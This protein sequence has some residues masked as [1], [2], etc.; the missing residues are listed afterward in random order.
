MHDIQTPDIASVERTFQGLEL[1][2]EQRDNGIFAAI[3]KALLS[4]SNQWMRAPDIVDRIRGWKLT[5][6]DGQLSGKT[7]TST[8]QGTI[9]TALKLAKSRGCEEPI[10]KHQIK[11]LTY[12]RL[13]LHLFTD[14][15][16][17]DSM[18][19]IPPTPPPDPPR[20][21]KD[22]KRSPTKPSRPTASS[23]STTKRITIDSDVNVITTKKIKISHNTSPTINLTDNEHDSQFLIE[24]S[25]KK[26]STKYQPSEDYGTPESVIEE[27]PTMINEINEIDVPRP[28]DFDINTVN[29]PK[30]FAIIQETGY[31]YSRLSRLRRS[32]NR[33]PKSKCEDAFCVKDLRRSDGSFM[34]RL[35]C[36]ADGHGGSGCSEFLISRVPNRIQEL[37]QDHP[38]NFDNKDEQQ[39]FR[40]QMVH[41]VR[42][43]DDEYVEAKRVEFR[44][45]KYQREKQGSIPFV[46]ENFIIN[47]QSDSD[48]MP[49]V[50]D[51]STIIINVFIN[52]WLIN[53]NVG[54]SRTFLACRGKNNKWS[55]EFA[56]EDHKPYLERLALKIY[57]NGGIFVDSNDDPIKFDPTPRQRRTRPSLK[58]ARIRLQGQE[59]ENEDGVPYINETGKY[60]SINVAA[61]CGDLLFK[62]NRSRRVI[63][64][65][66]DVT[67][68]K[69]GK[70][71]GDRFLLISSD[72]LFDHLKE[73]RIDE[74]NNEVAKFIGGLLDNGE[75]VM[76]VVKK[77]GSR[78]KY[79]TLFKDFSQ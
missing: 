14:S 23:R 43:L 3:V 64:C 65:I 46:D 19:T 60:W 42:Q 66:P 50:D 76:N 68:R 24:P 53:V 7:P 15:R 40:E 47:D 10:E 62:L 74:Q 55:V 63:D 27:E 77:I 48:S 32:E 51:G 16:I 33:Y 59:D 78:E 70:Y 4:N 56:S 34:A 73:S 22:K 67:F 41:L 9:S 49:P 5:T 8:I 28:I 25:L 12:Y 6:N 61:T 2:A 57:S 21:A 39:W 44:R 18:N 35:F 75:S 79:T 54:D 58:N 72:G 29:G 69:L 1:K 17:R 20:L 26:K 37:L 13:S 11:N 45:W 30:S 71:G 31:S 36:L 38:A 52:D